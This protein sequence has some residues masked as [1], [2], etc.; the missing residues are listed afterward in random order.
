MKF[1]RRIFGGGKSRDYGPPIV[2]ESEEARQDRIRR[3][4]AERARVAEEARRA[5][6]AIDRRNA[7]NSGLT[8]AVNSARSRATRQITQRGLNP[9]EFAALVEGSINDQRA[10]IPDLAENPASY[11]QDDFISNILNQEQQGRRENYTRQVGNIFTPNFE[12]NI[13][14]DTADD[15]IINDILGTGRTNAVAMVDRAKARGN[16]DDRGYQAALKRI[17]DLNTAAG[18]TA[19]QL[20]GN[21]LQGF[22]EEV[23]GIGD[24][25][26]TAAGS[27][28]LGSTFDPGVFTNELTQR[29]TDLTGQLPGAV[30]TALEGQDF[31][32]IGD[33]INFG[34]N[35]QGAQN[36]RTELAD[37]LAR[38]QQLRDSQR[39]QGGEGTF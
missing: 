6:E 34:G 16:L 20:G 13:F 39:G 7:F 19:Q 3:E 32:D 35:T 15:A 22:R 29:Q 2:T 26:R 36:P 11:F 1:L 10:L 18:S 23:R 38:R 25:A 24:R 5:Q 17:D 30:R 12:R 4:E 33:I 27:Y 37:V 8:N 28:T 31:F 14:S 9:D 21:V